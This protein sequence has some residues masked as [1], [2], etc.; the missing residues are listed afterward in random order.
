MMIVFIFILGL[1]ISKHIH[2]YKAIIEILYIFKQAYVYIVL[3]KKQS[4]TTTTIRKSRAQLLAQIQIFNLFA[5]RMI[6]HQ[7]KKPNYGQINMLICVMFGHLRQCCAHF[8]Q[9]Q[10]FVLLTLLFYEVNL[11]ISTYFCKTGIQYLLHTLIY[12]ALCLRFIFK[13]RLLPLVA[14]CTYV[15]FIC[16]GKESQ[17]NLMLIIAM[18]NYAFN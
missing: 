15:S 2:F 7:D 6:S 12:I 14:G 3:D 4:Q 5:A 13:L 1:E 8:L 17:Q 11:P 9:F 16:N 10:A 18:F